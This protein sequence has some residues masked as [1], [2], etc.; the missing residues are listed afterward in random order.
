MFWRE[1]STTCVI[2]SHIP[3][4]L[5]FADELTSALRFTGAGILASAN[6]GPNT[7]GSQFFITL[8]P[9]PHLDGKH[10]IFGR[11]SGGMS[12]VQRMGLVAVDANDRPKED[13]KILRA[14]VNA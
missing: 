7:N 2:F 11:V 4:A 8:A 6:S 10:T 14:D 12:I 9:T 1:K 3:S 13:V 5:Q